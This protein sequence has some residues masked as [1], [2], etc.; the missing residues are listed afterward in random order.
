MNVTRWTCNNYYFYKC[1]CEESKKSDDKPKDNAKTTNSVNAAT[2]KSDEACGSA[3]VAEEEAGAI[4]DNDARPVAEKTPVQDWFDEVVR[5]EGGLRDNE[6][7]G[8]G[9]TGN[10]QF[11]LRRIHISPLF[12]GGERQ[13]MQNEG[14]T[15]C[16]EFPFPIEFPVVEVFDSVPKSMFMHNAEM[17]LSFLNPFVMFLKGLES[18]YDMAMMALSP[19]L[20]LVVF[21]DWKYEG[22]QGGVKNVNMDRGLTVVTSPP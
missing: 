11:H 22:G 10:G 3:W 16:R 18:R 7:L 8:P 1:Q 9:G 15:S 4:L 5:G 2:I 6:E 19:S 12:R 17:L 13:L 14:L 20:F 21:A